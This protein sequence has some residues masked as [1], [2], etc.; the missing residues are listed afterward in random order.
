MTRAT[1]VCQVHIGV[2]WVQSVLVLERTHT[3][4]DTSAAEAAGAAVQQSS[5]QKKL[6]GKSEEAQRH[7]RMNGPD[8]PRARKPTEWNMPT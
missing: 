6:S 7:V 3:H 2:S 5:R 1:H 8:L 4:E